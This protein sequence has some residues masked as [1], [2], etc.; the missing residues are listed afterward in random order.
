MVLGVK[1]LFANEKKLLSGALNKFFTVFI[2]KFYW[3]AYIRDWRLPEANL[4]VYAMFT[5]SL[6]NFYFYLISK[7]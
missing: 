2:F 3:E 7:L 6:S 1:T 5:I 4:F